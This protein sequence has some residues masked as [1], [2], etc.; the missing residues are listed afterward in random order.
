VNDGFLGEAQEPRKNIFRLKTEHPQQAKL[1][2]KIANSFQ[3]FTDFFQDL[4]SHLGFAMKATASHDFTH[5][6]P[7]LP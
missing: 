3:Q 6:F 7:L 1:T 4:V 5:L 2:L